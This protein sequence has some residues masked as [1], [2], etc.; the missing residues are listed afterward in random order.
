M[1]STSLVVAALST[2]H[3]IGLASVGGA[4]IVFSLVSSFL[5]PRRNPN[6]P[7]KSG[8]G[9]YV[10]LGVLFFLAMMTAV[11]VFGRE[12]PEAEAAPAGP[13]P[14]KVVFTKTA[15][16]TCGSCHTLKDAGAT[17][18]IGPNLDQLKPVYEVVKR[19]VENGGGPMPAFKGK[20]SAQQIDDVSKY[21]SAV[22]GK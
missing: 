6:F 1:L 8:V 4:F 18:T 7:G 16:P 17:G 12:K 15:N 22:A 13:D 9:W 5:L 14:G 19:Q 21:V 3:R 10:L 2:A 20:L 11:L